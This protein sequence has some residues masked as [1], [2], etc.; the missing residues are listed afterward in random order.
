M[1]NGRILVCVSPSGELEVWSPLH[2]DIILW[3]VSQGVCEVTALGLPLL[4]RREVLGE[5]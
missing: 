3:T 5:L 2:G 4:H 1:T